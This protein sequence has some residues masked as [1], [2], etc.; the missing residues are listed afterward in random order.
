M[1]VHMYRTRE[2]ARPM[3]QGGM[4]HEYRVWCVRCPWQDKARTLAE[5]Q[6]FGQRH[7]ERPH[8]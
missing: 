7:V 8:R 2:E 1:A 6:A 3:R 5:A 4:T